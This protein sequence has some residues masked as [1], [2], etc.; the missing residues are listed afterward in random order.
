MTN[1]HIGGLLARLRKKQ[2]I[3]QRGV[4][5][6]IN[7]S[8]SYVCDV[9]KGRRGIR[10]MDPIV[11]L[12][13]AEYLNYP[14]GNILVHAGYVEQEFDERYGSYIRILRSKRR[15]QQVGTAIRGAKET[16]DEIKKLT[17]G[18]DP[19]VEECANVLESHIIRLETVLTHA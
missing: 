5:E 16:L 14:I 7:R 10:A 15:A 2:K 13:W 17:E 19:K 3:T 11:L 9:E 8:V 18:T 1:A 6:A 12:T 4:A